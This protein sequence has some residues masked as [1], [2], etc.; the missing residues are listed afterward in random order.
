M[1]ESP[2]ARILFAVFAALTVYA[3]LYPWTGAAWSF[4]VC[5]PHRA[6]A[7]PHHLLRRRGE[8]AGLHRTGFSPRQRC[9]RALR[10]RRAF[11]AATASAAVLSLM[12]EALQS[13]LPA[14]IASNLDSIC[15]VLGAAIGAAATSLRPEAARGRDVGAAAGAP[16]CA[17][18]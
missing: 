16:S 18:G 14:R 15:N 8:R 4:A 5:L 3:S 17:A 1:R 2:L 10:G 11:I 7:A 6:V 12:L 9:S 13:Y